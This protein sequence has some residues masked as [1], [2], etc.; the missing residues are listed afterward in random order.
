M[1]P[2]LVL[3]KIFNYLTLEDQLRIR[4]V[5]KLYQT[6]ADQII[7][8]ESKELILFYQILPRPLYWYHNNQLANLDNSII[9]NSKFKCSSFLRQLFKKATSLY[10]VTYEDLFANSEELN[11]FTN[12]FTNL[13]HLQILNL[14]NVIESTVPYEID[15]NLPNLKTLFIGHNEKVSSLNCPQLVQVSIFD[16]HH[17]EL[18]SNQSKNVKFLKL[19]SFRHLPSSDLLSL[20]SL[21]FCQNIQIDLT[22]Y[23]K[24]KELHF[25]NHKKAFFNQSE[26]DQ[27]L[28]Q[29][30]E[31][32]R[33]L[34]NEQ[35][36]IFYEGRKCNSINEISELIKKHK[37]YN[38][39]SL[40]HFGS[41]QF[42]KDNKEEFNLKLS[43]KVCK[44]SDQLNEELNE[45]DCDLDLQVLSRCIQQLYFGRSLKSRINFKN[46]INLFK[47]V[48]S[49]TI[50]QLAQDELNRLPSYLPMINEFCFLANDVESCPFINFDF[51]CKFKALK[52]FNIQKGLISLDEFKLILANC[53]YF[54]YAIFNSTI[55]YRFK[56]NSHYLRSTRYKEPHYFQTKAKLFQFLEDKNLIF[57]TNC[58]E[59]QE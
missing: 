52:C 58:K 45:I 43:Q 51:V 36:Q 3:I 14:N 49:I 2:D 32:K 4:S 18:D 27:I 56:N 50:T 11:G 59:N 44:Y 48:N 16:D 57:K 33:N 17:F 29:L 24:L 25:F 8:N 7:Q 15:L 35:L 37:F 5:C 42:Y 26:R 23:P 40:F 53:K 22:A 20:E 54:Y 30:L 39:A 28:N 12:F 31:Q 34:R 10:L 46:W 41:Y 9:V 6:I 47:Y 38:D 1:L 19:K 55:H 21:Y 13:E